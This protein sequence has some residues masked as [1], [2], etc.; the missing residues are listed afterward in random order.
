MCE[1][2]DQ[3]E[4][5][6]GGTAGSVNVFVSLFE[7]S[8][9]ASRSRARPASSLRC[10]SL[11]ATLGA[12]ENVQTN[13]PGTAVVTASADDDDEDMWDAVFDT[14]F[15][16]GHTGTC[17]RC[18]SKDIFPFDETVSVCDKCGYEDRGGEAPRQTA[19]AAVA[20]AAAAAA[21][22]HA[23]ARPASTA[24][25][26]HTSIGTKTQNAA[27]KSR[28]RAR[29]NKER[30]RELLRQKAAQRDP[31]RNYCDGMRVLSAVVRLVTSRGQWQC[32]GCGMENY[33]RK[34]EVSQ[35]EGKGGSGTI[36][37]RPRKTDTQSPALTP[38]SRRAPVLRLQA[39]EARV[40]ARPDLRVDL[41]ERF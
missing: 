22:A 11:T 31:F 29:R 28:A 33:E 8:R 37:A 3:R 16:G 40:K 27:D 20:A 1:G 35:G 5:E 34:D 39:Q 24:A 32:R 38:L 17:P 10:H 30:A 36:T 19:A 15:G 18:G 4:R 7:L 25:A 21:A 23:K 9:H 41:A 14:E 12:M 26:K 13:G 2:W 6:R